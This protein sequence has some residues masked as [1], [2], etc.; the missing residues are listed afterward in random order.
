MQSIKIDW[1]DPCLFF[2]W[3]NGYLSL[4][5]LWVNDSPIAGNKENVIK[6]KEILKTLFDCIDSD[7]M[8]EYVVCLVLRGQNWMRL[9]QPTQLRKFEDKFVLD[10][11]RKE[12]RTPSEPGSALNESEKGAPLSHKE[13][14]DYRKGVGILLHMMR[15]SRPEILNSVR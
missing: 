1:A 13:Q 15:W 14:H 3:Q 4:V 10:G 9:K 2:C 11:H 12:P 6:I 5:M 8:N 7:E